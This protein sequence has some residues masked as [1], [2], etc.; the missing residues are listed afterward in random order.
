VREATAEDQ[1]AQ[2][3]RLIEGGKGA[4]GHLLL[5]VNSMGG[6]R[7]EQAMDELSLADESEEL[8]PYVWWGQ[9]LVFRAQKNTQQALT[10]VFEGLT[11]ALVFPGSRPIDL[12]PMARLTAAL[13]EEAHRNGEAA[14]ARRAIRDFL[15]RNQTKLKGD[16]VSDFLR[17]VREAAA[18]APPG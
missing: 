18:P 15:D 2:A 13:A 17:R 5:A 1:A 11:S 8:R 3:Q 9:S 10:A 12:E 14:E 4:L 7:T 16:W 6:G